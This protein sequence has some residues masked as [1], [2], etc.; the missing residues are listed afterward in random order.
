MIVLI[1]TTISLA[2]SLIIE[3]IPLT[4]TP[5]PPYLYSSL[6]YLDSK[7]YSFGGMTTKYNNELWEFDGRTSKWRKVVYG[8]EILPKP[9]RSGILIGAFGKLFLYGGETDS[10]VSADLWSFDV[11]TTMWTQVSMTGDL[12]LPRSQP[13]FAFDHENFLYIFSGVTH[14]GPDSMLY[15]YFIYRLSLSTHEWTVLNTTNPPS[16]R[17]NCGLTHYSSYLFVWGGNLDDTSLYYLDLSTKNWIKAQTIGTPPLARQSFPIFAFQDF[18]YIFIGFLYDLTSKSDRCFRIGL[19]TFAWQEIDCPCQR[20]VWAYTEYEGYLALFGGVNNEETSNE[21]IF[22]D[23]T[24]SI[25]YF[26]VSENWVYPPARMKHSLLR[27]RSSLWLFGGVNN[28]E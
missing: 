21:L 19:T 8:S 2:T 6:A 11:E 14:K 9:R 28:D 4:G 27:T 25:R 13:G 7:I 16:P 3:E 15:R 1:L 20:I 26:I 12:P 22:G 24:S 10:G 17:C 18:I 5:P 23:F